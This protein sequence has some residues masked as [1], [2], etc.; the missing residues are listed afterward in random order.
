MNALPVIYLNRFHKEN[1][2]LCALYFKKDN[3]ILQRIAQN[4]WITWD[5]EEKKFVVKDTSNTIGLL[6]DIFEDIAQVNTHYY[7]AVLKNKTD[8]VVIGD[9][10]YFTDVLQLEEKPGFITLVPYKNKDERWIIV[11]YKYSRAV[12]QVLL[13]AKG[14]KWHEDLKEFVIHPKVSLLRYFIKQ[15]SAKLKVRVHNELEIKDYETIQLLYEQPYCKDMFFKSCPKQFLQHLQLK[16]YSRNTISTYYYYVLRFI[17]SYKQNS[18]DQINQFASAKIND[19]HQLML[20]HKKYSYQTINQSV[21]A[22]KVYYNSYLGKD[23]QLN[24]VVRP[25]VGKQLPKVWSKDEIRRIIASTENLKHKT[26]L[27]LLYG[28]G[29]RIGEVL[30]LKI[31]DIDSKRMRIRVLGAKGKKDRYTVL[32]IAQ[33]AVLR[34]YYKEYKPGN[35]LLEGQLGGKYSAASAGKILKK[36]ISRSGVPMRGGL[37]SLR[38]SFATH[39]LESGTDLR[40]IQ[41]LLGHNSSKTTEIYTHV[42]NKY[43]HHIKSPLDDLIV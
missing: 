6:V 12:N 30:N 16:G 31:G 36:A 40:Y 2:A 19:Y 3:I 29:L 32:G 27:S 18:L 15:V 10:T 41:E 37:H 17:N 20:G 9:A 5:V 11:K 39:L 34:K 4:D 35:Y 24:E 21:S 23:I 28:S 25:K 38:H 7:N 14:C 43:L 42:S 22:I 26:I 8:K 33:L 13:N 1:T